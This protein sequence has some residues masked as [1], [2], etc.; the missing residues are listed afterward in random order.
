MGYKG[1]KSGRYIQL[2]NEDFLMASSNYDPYLEYK[3]ASYFIWGGRVNYKEELGNYRVQGVYPDCQFIENASITSGRFINQ[4]D[5][6]E[7]KKVVVIGNV[8]KNELLKK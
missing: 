7:S 5:L 8:V 2:K 4:S 1:S 3:S 6:L